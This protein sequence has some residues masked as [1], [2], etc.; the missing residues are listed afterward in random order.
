MG[1][2]TAVPVPFFVACPGQSFGFGKLLAL[3]EK[4]QAT[5][6]EWAGLATRFQ[7]DA[8]VTKFTVRVCTG[9]RRT[10]IKSP[11]VHHDHAVKEGE[12]DASGSRRDRQWE[13]GVQLRVP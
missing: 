8:S 4:D 2:G 7:A 11:I 12:S 13:G 9:S 5:F 6:R 10:S 3:L 1:S